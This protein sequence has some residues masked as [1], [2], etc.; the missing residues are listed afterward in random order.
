MGYTLTSRW[1][2]K[3]DVNDS[4]CSRVPGLRW[5]RIPVDILNCLEVNISPPN[6]RLK[7]R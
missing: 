4:G 7:D 1:A 3:M 2:K 5:V 6:K